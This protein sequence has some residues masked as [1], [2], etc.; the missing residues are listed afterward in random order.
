MVYLDKERITGYKSDVL[1]AVEKIAGI[2]ALSDLG[3][4]SYS[5]DG[6]GLL[7]TIRPAVMWLL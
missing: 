2:I 4:I 5:L 7:Y 1:K 3:H 6:T